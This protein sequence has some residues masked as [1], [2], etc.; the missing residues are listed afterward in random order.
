MSNEKQ[1]NDLMGFDPSDLS[2]FE[3]EVKTNSSNPNIY[4][5]NPV[6]TKSED[7]H[8]YSKIRIL[9]NPHNIK[10]GSIVKNVLYSLE[11]T[12]G[13]F[14]ADSLLARGDRNCPIFKAWKKLHY[15]TDSKIY[16]IEGTDLEL[17]RQQWGDKMYD[18]TENNYVL[19]QIIEDENQPELVG[20]FMAM[21]LP[22][23]IFDILQNKMHPSNGAAPI[24]LMN[25]LFGPIL[26]MNVTPGEGKT[27]E[28][29]NR[30]IKYTLCEFDTDP[31]PIVNTDGTPLFDDDEIALI[32]EYDSLKKK[33]QKAKT[34]KDKEAKKKA[35]LD[36]VEKIKPLM[37]K[38]FEYIKNTAID[39]E[40]ECGYHEWSPELTE[41]VNNYINMVA[42][43]KSP[44]IELNSVANPVATSTQPTQTPAS[45]SVETEQDDLPF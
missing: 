29:R 4:K 44:T 16:K 9:Y 17:T 32:E 14:L 37:A 28:E 8:Y 39:I 42:E 7:G 2:A 5:T 13:R 20:K 36:L 27:Q 12:N 3:A 31:C 30:G 19:V 26:N 35:C 40:K 41:R 18:K 11:D 21:R 23:A 33:W 25:Y 22:K 38:A 6:N 24:D 43:M 45:E 34:E 10:N 15:S 1:V